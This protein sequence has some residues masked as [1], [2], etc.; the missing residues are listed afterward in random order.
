MILEGIKTTNQIITNR[1]VESKQS[2]NINEVGQKKEENITKRVNILK[3]NEL[4]NKEKLKKKLEIEKVILEKKRNVFEKEFKLY[5]IVSIVFLIGILAGTIYFRLI[6][7][8]VEI[9]D[10]ISQRFSLIENVN[11]VTKSD[12]L[13]TSILKNIKLLGAFWIIGVSVIGFPFLMFL[14]AYKG[15]SLAFTIS[16]ILTNMGFSNGN[17]FAFKTLFLHTFFTVLAIFILMV[18]SLKLSINV[19][20]NK[21]D[22]RLE[23]IRHTIISTIAIIFF[24][25]SIFFETIAV[26]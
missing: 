13:K 17:V 19:L 14:C 3:N 12:I 24:G 16:T 5:F 7:N 21:K 11:D 2:R 26:I 23:I 18:S 25:I 8:D 6:I 4:K 20:K 10:E 9:R 22:I 15:F 1:N